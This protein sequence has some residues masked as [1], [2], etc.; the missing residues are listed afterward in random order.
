MTR[1]PTP[2]PGD[3][4]PGFEP[5]Y[6]ALHRSGELTKRARLAA[7]RMHDCDLCARYCH[8]DRMENLNGVACRTGAEAKVCSFGPHYGEEDPLRGTRASGTIFFSFCNMRCV[9]CQNFDAS[10]EGDGEGTSARGLADMMLD[11]QKQGCHNVNFVSPSHVV[12]QIIE[13]VGI[14]AEGGL[15]I[16]LVYNSGGYDSPEALKLLDGIIDI[17]M[18]DMKYGDPETARKYSNIR[19]YVAIN[20]AVVSEMY[21]QVGPLQLDG[22]GVAYRGLLVRHLILPD[23]LADT[24]IVLKFLADNISPDTYLNLMAQYR[25]SHKAA[26]Y[27]ELA[28]RPSVG[29]LRQA[30]ELAAKYGLTRLDERLPA[31]MTS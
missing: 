6:L 31:W 19:D 25:P 27:P 9:Y 24:D 29:D 16:P 3:D 12:A 22:A 23:G 4:N 8:V 5:A 7:M 28:K 15:N 18:P 17:Y 21:A 1:T 30:Q 26:E 14:A 11:L 13:A 10:W 2:R 20:R